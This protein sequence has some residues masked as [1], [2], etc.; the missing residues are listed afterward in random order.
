MVVIFIYIIW[1]ITCISIPFFVPFVFV[2]VWVHVHLLSSAAFLAC[3]DKDDV[4][5]FVVFICLHKALKVHLFWAV[6]LCC[7]FHLVIFFVCLLQFSFYSGQQTIIILFFFLFFFLWFFALFGK[8]YWLFGLFWFWRRFVLSV[9][10]RL[11]LFW[12]P[13]KAFLFVRFSFFLFLYRFSFSFLTLPISFEHS[14]TFLAFFLFFKLNFIK[15]LHKLNKI[16]NPNISDRCF[17]KN[18]EFTLL[19]FALSLDLFD[20]LI[21]EVPKRHGQQIVEFLRI[22]FWVISLFFFFLSVIFFFAYM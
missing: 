14:F 21:A 1:I 8:L 16:F 3:W 7:H 18:Q 11:K 20:F 22:I 6:Y 19:L 2:L 4:N 9:C 12:I 10:F 17:F 15:N 5:L 13:V